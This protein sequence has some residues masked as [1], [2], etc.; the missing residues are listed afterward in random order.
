MP[1]FLRRAIG[2][3]AMIGS[4]LVGLPAMAALAVFVINRVPNA[5]IYGIV[6]AIC[7]V[8]FWSGYRMWVDPK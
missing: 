2:L 3:V 8:A 6:A 4:G 1:Y 7:V 5:A